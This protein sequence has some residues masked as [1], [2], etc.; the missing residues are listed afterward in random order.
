M[1]YL[2][3]IKSSPFIKNS[4]VLMAGTI[5]SQAI[6]IGLAPVL[7][8]IFDKSEFALYYLYFS[9]ITMFFTLFTLRYEQA[10]VLPETKREANHLIVLASLIS[11]A[12]GLFFSVSCFFLRDQIALW[13]NNTG[14]AKWVFM[15]PIA[16]TFIGVY[17]AFNYFLTREKNFLGS[18]INRITQ[19]VVEGIVN[20]TT[21]LLHIP[22]GQILGDFSGR[23]GVTVMSSSQSA[24][25]GFTLKDFDFKLMK[26]LAKRYYQFAVYGSFPAFLNSVSSNIPI[27]FVSNFFNENVVADFG[28]SRMIL[29]MPLSIISVNISQVLLQ[30][31]V[32]KKNKGENVYRELKKIFLMLL[33]FSFLIFLVLQFF[34]PSIFAFVLGAKWETAGAYSSILATGFAIR[35]AVSPLSCVF[36]AYERVKSLSAWQMGYFFAILSL[37]L[38]PNLSIESF[39][40]TYTIIDVVSYTIYLWLIRR[41]V[42]KAR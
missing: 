37:L 13:V 10:V 39:L 15:V 22:G 34:A 38:F 12:M 33:A 4:A 27:L 1:G 8:R 20:I 9:G 30:R 19:R 23:I 40:W 29:A 2:Q 3:K 26:S 6:P 32:E 21:G 16:M 11:I 35:F 41:A 24:R 5:L 18:S 7:A 28:Y 31:I 25:L 36:T 42:L 17:Q 14:F